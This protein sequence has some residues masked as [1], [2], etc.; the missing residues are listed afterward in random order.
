MFSEHT[1]EFATFQS[2]IAASRSTDPVA[3][4]Y[5]RRCCITHRHCERSL[6]LSP[7][8]I[9]PQHSVLTM[10]IPTNVATL[11][12]PTWKAVV[13]EWLAQDVPTF[14]V[15]GA[16]VGDAPAEAALLCKTS[17]ILA[18]VPF[19][20]A[21]FEELSCTV[22]WHYKEGDKVIAPAKVATVSGPCRML[23][24]GERTALNILSRASGVCSASR[25]LVDIARG[26]GWRGEVAGTRKVTPGF[27]L[28]EKYALLVGGAST[29][30]MDLSHMVMLKG[31]LAGQ[32]RQHVCRRGGKQASA[33]SARGLVGSFLAMT[34][35][36]IL[37]P[38]CTDNHVWAS[39]SITAAVQRARQLCGFSSK[40][41]VEARGL[42]EAKEAA[43]AGAD[44][45]MLDN[46]STAEALAGDARALKELYPH[47]IV[48]ASGGITKESLPRY[49][50]P[51]VDVVSLGALTHGYHVADF[52]LKIA[53][54]EGKD[55][56]AQ[57]LSK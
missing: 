37:H 39:G 44:I 33:C 27:R 9:P 54:G 48:E 28:V 8:L 1:E 35:T 40:I 55:R 32:R 43:A 36:L 3:V 14:D 15:G 41:E 13:R 50:V 46:Y 42:A 12:P 17:T 38:S 24:L 29:H 57:T 11:L 30:R 26:L 49:C 2:R 5:N 51:G 21:V 6:T 34:R 31:E 20:D 45:V 7:V 53:L 22:A 25:E 19:F 56:I 47:I 18:G 23:L 16:V 4:R 10:D 52:S